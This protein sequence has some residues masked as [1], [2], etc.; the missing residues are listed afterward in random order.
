MLRIAILSRR[1]SVRAGNER[2]AVELGRQMHARGHAVKVYASKD[3]GSVDRELLGDPRHV[4]HVPSIG[5]APTLA[6]LSYAWTTRRLVE[7]LRAERA[8]DVVIGFGH[9]VVHDVYRL[10]GGTH[11]EFVRL[12]AGDRAAA[13]GLVLD[14]AALALEAVRF[15][16]AVS[17]L[18]VAPSLRVGDELVRHYAVDRARIRTVWNGIDLERFSPR[19]PQADERAATRARWGLDPAAPVALFVGQDPARKGFEHAVH[20]AREVGVP[21]V[22]VGRAPRP[23]AL[24]PG[25][26]W[27]GERRDVEAC[28]RAADVLFAPSRY[29]PFG[30]AVLEALAAGCLPVATRRIGATERTLGT[31]LDALL[32]DEPDDVDGLVRGAR[33][34][35]DPARR[36][37]LLAEAYRV[38]REAG[39]DAWGDAM[40]AVLEE[41]ARRY[42]S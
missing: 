15:R 28:Y 7:R 26:V 31:P 2:V 39:R 34:A 38:T 30:G 19:P 40:E 36:P 25:V 32:V 17:P 4:V 10:G 12:A 27:D 42:R 24:P 37:A 21:L 14:R 16:P 1:W 20:A 5:F 3:D 9:S 41:G 6:L 8:V 35:L 13:G 11:A 22:Y 18:L 29:D 33:L 23:A